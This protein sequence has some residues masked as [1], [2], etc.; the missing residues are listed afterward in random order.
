[1]LPYQLPVLC[2]GIIEAVFV[3]NYKQTQIMLTKMK[4]KACV[5]DMHTCTHAYTQS[6]YTGSPAFTYTQTV[7]MQSSANYLPLSLNYMLLL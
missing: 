6:I 1:M 3:H 5:E 7:H 2:K 4:L